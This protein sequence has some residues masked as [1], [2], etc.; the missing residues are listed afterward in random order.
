MTYRAPQH[1]TLTRALLIALVG[2]VQAPLALAQDDGSGEEKA[3]TLDQ[4]TV[5]AQKRE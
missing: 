3:T 5:T 1:S 4:I 2:L